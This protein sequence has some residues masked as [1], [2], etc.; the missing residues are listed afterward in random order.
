MEQAKPRLGGM[1]GFIV[2]WLGQIVSVLASGMT[3][4]AL[5]L[6]IYDQTK[7]AMAF[8]GM[9]VSYILPFLLMSPI[10]GVWVDRYNRKLMMMVSDMGAA[11]GTML[12][13]IAH[14]MGVLEF[15]HLYVVSALI[16]IGNTFQW[17]AYSAAISTMVPK[18]QYGRANG[19]M[20]VMEAG[21]AVLAPLMA[22]ALLPIIGFNWILAIDLITFSFAIG[23]LLVVH[24]PDPEKTVEGQKK[25]GSV[26]SE[27]W[28]G[29]QYIFERPSL[30]GLQMIFLFG[31]LFSGMAFTLMAP[32]ILA[33]TNSNEIL[34]G[35]IQSI[36]AVGGLAGGIIM[37][38]WGGFK[39]R[40]HGVLMGWVI[41]SL[42]GMTLLGI[43]RGL[44]VWI[45]AAVF[46][47]VP[48]ALINTSNQA[49][50]Q[51]KVAPDLQG[52]VFSARRLIAWFTQPISPLIA[53]A[54]A[55]YVLE[56]RMME[57]G[58]LSGTFGW[59]VGTGAGAGMGLVFVFTGV[60]AALVGLSGYFFPAIRNAEDILPDHDQLEKVEA[61]EEGELAAESA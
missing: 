31:N 18:E 41:T 27:A 33:R 57:G 56:P 17:P 9:Q 15:W 10:A 16:G 51:A 37:S 35:T 50:W 55:D 7:S 26:W 12:V 28:Y 3:Q 11:L 30:L 19:L 44:V 58:S 36:M 5:T 29:F 46:V 59:L 39:R 24:I 21:P 14:S 49:I 2:V 4:F 34:F 54:L 42:F 13:L 60:L 52:R 45:V 48:N 61:A 23:A 47:T 8:A 38:A 22:G 40:V 53:G 32:M 1:K 25:S 6:W 20:S 43:G